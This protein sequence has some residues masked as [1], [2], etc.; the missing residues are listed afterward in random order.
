MI[1]F[2]GKDRPR[3]ANVRRP[4]KRSTDGTLNDS[5]S[6]NGLLTDENDDTSQRDIRPKTPI[7]IPSSVEPQPHESPV[8]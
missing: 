5:S 1:S 3:R 8:S 2:L 7:D 6:D 4:A